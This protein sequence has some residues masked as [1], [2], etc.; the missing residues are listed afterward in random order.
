ME[1]FYLEEANILRKDDAIE[2][3]E[4]FIKYN[5]N[6]N[7]V[8]GLDKYLNRY[9]EW[10]K[11]LESLKN[12][13][14]TPKNYCPGFEYFLI[15]ENDNKLVGMINLRYNLNKKM[16]ISGGN[17]GYSIRP[18]ERRKGYNKINLFLCL[19]QAHKLNLNKVLLTAYDYNMGSVKTILSLDGVLE[20]KKIDE[21]G[22]Y[23]RYF[24]D[25]VES[26]KKNIKVYKKYISDKNV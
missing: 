24:I 16:L 9:E 1:K 13:I 6:I 10:L 11:F 3:I 20:N 14:T 17:I 18:L 22:E 15:R 4:E 5:S 21:D 19:L 7:G 26:I 8:C 23:G 12:P 2:Y 25:V